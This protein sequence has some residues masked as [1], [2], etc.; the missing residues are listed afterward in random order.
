MNY[1]ILLLLL[2]SVLLVASIAMV[3]GPRFAPESVQQGFA[4]VCVLAAICLLF[5]RN[6]E[7]SGRSFNL[8]NFCICLSIFIPIAIT[9]WIFNNF[10]NPLLGSNRPFEGLYAFLLWSVLML[11]LLPIWGRFLRVAGFISQDETRSFR[12]WRAFD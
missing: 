9:G 1:N 6:R 2:G 11:G 7:R 10:V 5:R 3:A 12:C 4:I 8:R